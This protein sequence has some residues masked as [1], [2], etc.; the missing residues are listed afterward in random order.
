MGFKLVTI[1]LLSSLSRAP[2]MPILLLTLL[3]PSILFSARMEFLPQFPC[4]DGRHS[5]RSIWAHCCDFSSGQ[6]LSVCLTGLASQT[7]RE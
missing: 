4:S 7:L 5:R 1:P 2:L 3:P 6:I